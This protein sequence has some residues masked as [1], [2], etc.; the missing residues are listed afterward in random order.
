[1]PVGF[2]TLPLVFFYHH[3]LLCFTHFQEKKPTTSLWLK[4]EKLNSYLQALTVEE[5]RSEQGPASQVSADNASAGVCLH[6]SLFIPD[7]IGF[8]CHPPA[9]KRTRQPAPQDGLVVVLTYVRND[10][11]CHLFPPE[12]F[13]WGVCEDCGC[14]SG[15]SPTWGNNNRGLN[16]LR[17]AP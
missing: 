4:A 17:S 11:I 2:S 16:A 5:A 10:K 1:M 9:E 15:W 3:F 6:I 8:H 12:D 13:T 14:F 7:S